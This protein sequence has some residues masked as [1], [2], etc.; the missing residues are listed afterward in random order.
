MNRSL[1]WNVILGGVLL[2]MILAYTGIAQTEPEVEVVS[3]W[4]SPGS[5]SVSP[6]ARGAEKR[7][8]EAD[9][10]IPTPTPSCLELT[11][12]APVIAQVRLP[13]RIVGGVLIPSHMT[14]VVLQPGAWRPAHGTDPRQPATPPYPPGCERLRHPR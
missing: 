6:T 1:P 10:P 7:Q 14:Y 9:A 3:P 13:D 4:C 12:R 2:S 8:Q 11:Y 5:A